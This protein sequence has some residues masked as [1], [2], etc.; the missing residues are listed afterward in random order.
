MADSGFAVEKGIADLPRRK[1]CQRRRDCEMR[2][3]LLCRVITYWW[4]PS[5]DLALS[6]A[7]RSAP[8]APTPTAAAET[9]PLRKPLAFGC[10][11]LPVL[12][13]LV[14]FAGRALR[15]LLCGV[16]SWV[17]RRVLLIVA[18]R[19]LLHLLLCG[20]FHIVPTAV[21]VLLPA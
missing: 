21:V 11:T 6:G 16:T 8:S 15:P 18:L 19:L 4:R 13:R 2:T 1:A 9:L 12:C 17:V 20:L 7:S 3:V 14:Q 10:A 5:P